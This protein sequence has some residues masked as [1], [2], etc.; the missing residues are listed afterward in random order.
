VHES[1]MYLPENC[2][3]R[4]SGSITQSAHYLPSSQ[5]SLGRVL[6]IAEPCP[7]SAKPDIEPT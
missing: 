3:A 4:S 5:L 1:P 6:I 7:L 2:C